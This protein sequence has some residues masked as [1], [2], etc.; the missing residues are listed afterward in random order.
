M[1]S[2]Y[3]KGTFQKITLNISKAIDDAFDKQFMQELGDG[4]AEQI[5]KRTRLGKG[6]ESDGG[7]QT[8]LGNVTPKWRDIK[9]KRGYKYKKLK[10]QLSAT[11]EMLDSLHATEAR[12]RS[13]K[14]K[15]R[16]QRNS[17]LARYHDKDG[18]GRDRIKSPFFN[19]TKGEKS[20]VQRQIR[21]RLKEIFK[22]TKLT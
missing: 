4:V 6:V 10:K 3:K 14:I 18:A 17:D 11:G 1:S 21:Q 2:E 7:Q 15:F 5:R 20:K 19:L 16:G 12:Q 9:K 13:V 22:K 8:D